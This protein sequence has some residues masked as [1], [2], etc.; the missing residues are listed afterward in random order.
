M[1]GKSTIKYLQKATGKCYKTI[2]YHHF[3][4]YLEVVGQDL[5]NK[6]ANIQNWC[7]DDIVNMLVKDKE[8]EGYEED[9]IDEKATTAVPVTIL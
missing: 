9:D 8:D 5:V 4:G 2:L 3:D 1:Q 7:W 6:L